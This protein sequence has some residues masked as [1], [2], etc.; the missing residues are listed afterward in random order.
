VSKKKKRDW[1]WLFPPPENPSDESFMEWAFGAV[2]KS[3]PKESF[4]EWA[5]GAVDKEGLKSKES[6][7]EWFIR[8]VNNFANEIDTEWWA[9]RKINL[10]MFVV[11]GL[12][13]SPI[14]LGKT[15]KRIFWGWWALRKGADDVF[16]F[17]FFAITVPLLVIGSSTLIIAVTLDLIKKHLL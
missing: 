6:F 17:R 9:L 11:M 12:R 14:L 7:S 8:V 4:M 13:K 15:S 1:D 3:K 16:N 10:F 2:D 5:F